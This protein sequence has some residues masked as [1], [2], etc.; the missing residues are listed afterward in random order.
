MTV[1]DPPPLAQMGQLSDAL[2]RERRKLKALQ[3][4]GAALGSTLDLDE[5]LSM[6]LDRIGQV[7]E[8][9]RSTLYLLDEDKGELW[10]KIA[11]GTQFREIR[12]RVGEGLAGWVAQTGRTLNIRDAY[13]DL[14]FDGEW[15]RRTGYRTRSILGVPMKNHHGRTIGVVQVLN[16]TSGD[17]TEDDEALLSALSSQAAVCIENSKLFLSVVGK[18]IEL[19]ETKEA[20]ERKV[21]ELDVLFEIAQI[22]ASTDGLE[23]LLEG[24]LVRAMRAMEAT[25]A[26]ILLVEKPLGA[27]RFRSALEAESKLH[28]I[29]VPVGEGIS[30]W[31]ATHQHAQVVGDVTVDPRHSERLYREFGYVAKS[32]LCV[33]MRWDGGI[34]AL[35]LIDKNQG[36]GAFCEDEVKFATVIAGHAANAIHLAESRAQRAREDRLS[37]IGQF[38]SGVLH[39]LRTPMTVVSGYVQMLVDEEDK[40]KRQGFGSTALRQVALINSMTRETLAFARGDRTLWVRKVYLHRFFEELVEQLKRDLSESHVT[41]ELDLVY[42]GVAYFDA[43]KIQRAIHNLAR[44]ASEAIGAK[45]GLFRIRVCKCEQSGDLLLSFRDDGSGI[46]EAIRTRLFDS[47]TTHGKSGGSGLGLAIVRQIVDAHG[48]SIKLESEPGRTVFTIRLPL[49]FRQPS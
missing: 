1:E 37:S 20:L 15:D 11:Q 8:A 35:A 17:F 26:S 49:A 24:V 38:L 31:V 5:L 23:E 19:L 44:N 25:A 14:R 2:E 40:E 22:S 7:M 3:D 33:P 6:V 28:C 9:D 10:S 12:L 47:F 30:S 34:G 48:G 39:D 13:Q 46:P 41:V 36:D 18:N 29:H 42:R 21:C 45:G 27:L 43:Q 32:M 16:K 4:I